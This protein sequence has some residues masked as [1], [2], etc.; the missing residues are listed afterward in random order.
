M[1]VREAVGVGRVGEGVTVGWGVGV[2][3]A[4]VGVSVGVAGVQAARSRQATRRRR[5]FMEEII[6]RTV[7]HGSSAP[8]EYA[9]GQARG[10]PTEDRTGCGTKGGFD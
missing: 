3:A 1:G 2:G 9:S 10:D 5:R 8:K 4:G 6:I 7:S